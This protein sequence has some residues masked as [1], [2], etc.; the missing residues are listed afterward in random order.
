MIVLNSQ[1][2]SESHDFAKSTVFY[3]KMMCVF[4]VETYKILRASTQNIQS[5]LNGPI[6][7][8]GQTKK[9]KIKT[10]TPPTL[11]QGLYIAFI[12][13]MQANILTICIQWS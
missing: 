1:F 8:T 7:F 12:E 9:K 11:P 10:G 6:N 5:I 4:F 2:N 13:I 3:H